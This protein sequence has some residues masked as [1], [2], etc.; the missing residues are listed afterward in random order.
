M[1]VVAGPDGAG[2]DS[3]L[4]GS[5]AALRNQVRF[6]SQGRYR[7]LA[8]AH[9][10]RHG[11]QMRCRAA[12]LP[13][14][15]DEVYPLALRHSDSWS[16]G[17][18]RLVQLDEVLRRQSGRYAVAGELGEQ[19]RAAASGGLCATCV[20]SPAWRGDHPADDQIPCPEPCSVL[21]SLCREAALWQRDPPAPSE[22]NSAIAF[23]AFDE[24][25]NEVREA[26]LAARYGHG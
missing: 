10:L 7:P 19:G 18:L 1:A 11:W 26:Y 5:A 9:S 13:A 4:E 8:G 24:P 25:G 14:L 6:D 21:V 22:P 12:E 3:Q 16:R 20:K 23:A 2:E 17:T 15:L